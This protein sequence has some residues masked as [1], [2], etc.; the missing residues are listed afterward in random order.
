MLS[1]SMEMYRVSKPCFGK[2]PKAGSQGNEYSAPRQGT[3]P[4]TQTP[5]APW[6]VA[7]IHLSDSGEAP[8]NQTCKSASVYRVAARS[9]E[10]LRNATIAIYGGLW[11][12]A[13]QSRAMPASGPALAGQLHFHFLLMKTFTD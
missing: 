11:Q 4:A 1:S 2:E 5:S 13:G 3:V 8:K 10:Q 9:A 7:I 12:R 6:T